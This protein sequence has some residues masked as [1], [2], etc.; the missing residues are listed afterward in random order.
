MKVHSS[1]D[2]V[3]VRWYDNKAVDLVSTFVGVETMGQVR[4]LDK[5]RMEYV[6]VNRPAIVEQYNAYMGGVDL[7]EAL[8]AFI[9]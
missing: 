1:S 2:F 3:A 7:M 6:N 8:S 5:T 9:I 4:R